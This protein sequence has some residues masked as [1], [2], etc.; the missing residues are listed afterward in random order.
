LSGVQYP[1]VSSTLS[2]WTS[3]NGCQANSFQNWQNP[4]SID[5]SIADEETT[6]YSAICPQ[7]GDVTFWVMQGS[8]HFPQLTDDFS[9]LV[10]TYLL[11]Q[12]NQ[13]T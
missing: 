4:F 12:T 6:S 3:I 13:S 11:S 2:S 5:K 9:Q 10:I 8:G 1:S 7:G